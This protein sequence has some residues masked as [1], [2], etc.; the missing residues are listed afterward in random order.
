MS[1]RFSVAAVV[2]LCASNCG[3]SP[4]A[5]DLGP[6]HDARIA[7]R[8]PPA[9]D[10]PPAC[11]L[12]V[13]AISGADPA[14]LRAI[15]ATLD[16][17]ADADGIQLDVD[18]EVIGKPDGTE[19]ALEV[20]DVSPAPTA[21]SS[22]G[23][24][25][26]KVIT[27]DPELTPLLTIHPKADG[28]VGTAISY[29]V[30][31]A[32]SCM[33]VSPPD[34]ALLFTRD[35]KIAGN[36]SFDVDVVVATESLGG[37]S[38]DL[39]VD[40]TQVAT[41]ARG[42]A[43]GVATF[44][45]VALPR[46]PGGHVDLL[47]TLRT[48]NVMASCQAKL[49][50]DTGGPPCALTA[51]DPPAFHTSK[52]VGFGS[53]QDA[54]PAAPGV[55]STVTV[56]TAGDGVELI[57]GGA[58]HPAGK[59]VPQAG[60][61]TFP[62]D[63]AAGV[64]IAYARCSDTSTGNVGPSLVT[65]LIV[66]LDAPE[67]VTDLT[68][69]VTQN[70]KGRVA[71]R[72]TVPA[73]GVSGS[74]VGRCLLH[75]RQDSEIDAS[76]FDA[77]DTVKTA[78][79]VTTGIGA[80]VVSGLPL[81]HAYDFALKC[82]DYAGNASALSEPDLAPL[83][84]DFVVEQHAGDTPGV[85]MGASIAAGDFN[86]DGLTDLAAGLHLANSEA[87]VVRLYFSDGTGFA[88]QADVQIRGTQAGKRFGHDLVALDHDADGCS[89]LAVNALGDPGGGPQGR[90]YLYLGRSAW[91]ERTDEG[92]PLA[93]AAEVI[94]ALSPAA[95]SQDTLGRFFAAGDLD[96]DGFT[97]LALSHDATDGSAE[98]LIA[99][100]QAGATKLS[101]GDPAPAPTEM[102]QAAGLRIV[103]GSVGAGF[104]GPLASAG[105]LDADQ[106][107]ELL[108]GAPQ[109]VAGGLAVGAAYVVLGAARGAAP[110]P[111]VDV[112][113]SA[114]ALRIDGEYGDS[115]FGDRLGG[116]GDTN[117]DGVSEF[118]VAAYWAPSPTGASKA[119]A[120]YVFDLSGSPPTSAAHAAA[121]VLNDLADADDD[122]LGATIGQGI[123]IAGA[124][125]DWDGYA[126]LVV[127]QNRV[128]PTTVGAV[129]LF[130]GKPGPL[131]DRAA[132][133]AD[134]VL[135]PPAAG[136]SSFGSQTHVMADVNGDGIVDLAIGEP[137]FDLNTGRV[138]I[139][140]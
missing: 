19:V 136:T 18:V 16:R 47:A 64:T 76:N 73:D 99:F 112:V 139:Y 49:T 91:D 107:E 122:E 52:G 106:R 92:E 116:T 87:G 40:G 110:E 98:V 17:D 118:A 127:S 70:R 34:G 80:A 88:P 131:S 68:C 97:D 25:S 100:G 50:L 46:T 21:V 109:T 12:R 132:S 15:D 117:G 20:T 33:F 31:T 82:Q 59:V 6:E 62:L 65:Q 61:A 104:G 2:L 96:G 36:A 24:A 75:Y 89:D 35:D 22:A 86:C 5:A 114:R 41:G 48:G 95:G 129:R 77:P 120:I 134:L 130:F 4:P 93:P 78:H 111:P 44:F 137:G 1:V 140:R 14:G 81:A 69:E 121:V 27:V 10:A 58:V 66:D 94:Y 54:D 43:R 105:D 13:T 125:L 115:R 72:F 42:D 37:G 83:Q 26:F 133:A 103:G 119:G 102:P 39:F 11:T 7:D 56:S 90:V 85:G 3:D 55:Q 28:C 74:G 53:A 57:V 63:L 84:V 29:A 123:S 71:C 124:D 67:A 60:K 32:P 101:P 128:G 38:V 126:D 51:F 108:I 30:Q 113:T 138:L 135:A 8:S 9:P 79:V 45:A 23:A